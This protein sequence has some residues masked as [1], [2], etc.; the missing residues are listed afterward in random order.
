[1]KL[2]ALLLLIALPAGAAT[3]VT[4]TWDAPTNYVDGSTIGAG[5]LVGYLVQWGLG[6]FTNTTA[7]TTNQ[8][9]IT[10]T[11]QGQYWHR[12]AAI[13]A[14]TGSYCDAVQWLYYV[15]PDKPRNWRKK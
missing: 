1:M 2:I 14:A 8:V 7:A 5:E 9:T 4:W 6:S 13:C 15:A 10:Y 11:T 3:N 12:C